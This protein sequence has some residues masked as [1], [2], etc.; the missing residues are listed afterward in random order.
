MGQIIALRFAGDDEF[1]AL[2]KQAAD[3]NLSSKQIK[4]AI[5]NWRADNNRA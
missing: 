5:K 2:A 1:V 3:E 4:M